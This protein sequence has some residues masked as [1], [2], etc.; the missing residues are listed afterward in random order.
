MIMYFAKMTYTVL[1]QI[2]YQYGIKMIKYLRETKKNKRNKNIMNLTWLRIREKYHNNQPTLLQIYIIHPCQILDFLS[3]ITMNINISIKCFHFLNSNVENRT[4]STR[5]DRAKRSDVKYSFFRLIYDEYT[6]V[7]KYLTV[8]ESM[9]LIAHAG[10]LFPFNC[11]EMC[12]LYLIYF[13][14]D[15]PSTMCT[16]SDTTSKKL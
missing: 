16:K 1:Y 10:I 6:L 4:I 15:N 14:C 7:S 9:P 5:H 8:K 11:S 12:L 2:Q 13:F 3:F